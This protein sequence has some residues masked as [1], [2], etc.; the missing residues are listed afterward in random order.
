MR[1]KGTPSCSFYNPCS[2]FHSFH[3]NEK[4]Q[5]PRMYECELCGKRFNSGNA[6]GGHKTSHRRSHLQRHDKYD[7][8]KQKH[9]CP[10]CNKVFSSNK[11][12]CGHM[13]LHHEKGS[14][15]I[16]SPTTFLE[17]F[18]FQVG[19]APPAIDL[20]KYSPPKSHK[21]KKNLSGGEIS[22]IMNILM[23]HKHSSIC[24]ALRL[25]VVVIM[26]RYIKSSK[27][28]AMWIMT[29]SR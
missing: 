16:H 8:E 23:E 21:I 7:D 9:R 15:S 5:G 17:Q 19:I 27:F 22:L 2:S 20:T 6:L 4:S 1:K 11:A 12:F 26:V 18:Q 13:I 28:Q 14:K 10:V 3:D 25:V 29:R 24:L